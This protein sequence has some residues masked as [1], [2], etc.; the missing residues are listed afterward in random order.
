MW[1]QRHP[2]PICDTMLCA[3]RVMARTNLDSDSNMQDL[4]PRNEGS[5]T[6]PTLQSM[7]TVCNAQCRFCIGTV[8]PP[9]CGL[10]T[11]VSAGSGGPVPDLRLRSLSSGPGVSV[12]TGVSSDRLNF[13]PMPLIQ[14]SLSSLPSQYLR[15]IDTITRPSLPC[16]P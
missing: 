5:T 6:I 7:D 11:S 4:S 14:A 8:N 2:A 12:L 1:S 15:P 9:C 10:W 13:R 3:V 16:H